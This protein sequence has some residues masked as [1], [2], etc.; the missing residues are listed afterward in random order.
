MS[1]SAIALWAQWA[2]GMVAVEAYFGTIKL[3][4]W[5]SY[6]WMAVVWFALGIMFYSSQLGWHLP[7]ALQNAVIEKLEKICSRS[8]Q[9]AA[10]FRG[11]AFFTLINYCVT[12]EKEG[13]WLKNLV[14]SQLTNIGIFSYSLYLVHYP[15]IRALTTVEKQLRGNLGITSVGPLY[16]GAVYITL[17]ALAVLSGKAL[18]FLVERRC[19]PSPTRGPVAGGLYGPAETVPEPTLLQRLNPFAW[20]RS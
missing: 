19:L 4:R 16:Y 18:F 9:L 15:L 10:L 7:A 3:P 8:W 14:A 5:C 20:L 1:N 12:R 13:R 2:L 11:L 6:W 17:A